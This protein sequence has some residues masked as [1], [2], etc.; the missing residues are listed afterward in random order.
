MVVD[1]LLRLL[2]DLLPLTDGTDWLTQAT[3]SAHE[4]CGP[5][6]HDASTAH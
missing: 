2:K 6:C 4:L 1:P 5:A 3:V